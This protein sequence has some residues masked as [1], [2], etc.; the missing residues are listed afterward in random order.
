MPPAPR[1]SSTARCGKTSSVWKPFWPTAPSSEPAA[2]PENPL[3]VPISCLPEAIRSAKAELEEIDLIAPLS[4]HVGDGN[5]HF[6]LLIDREDPREVDLA[7]RFHERLVKN[8]IALEGTAS[9]EHGI[10]LGK[11]RFLE[12]EH[13]TG[14]QIM[15]AIKRA[16]DPN[17][18]LNPGKIFP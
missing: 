6:V 3:P 14:L 15:R 16:L 1:P 12:L 13:G 11:S 7:E 2:G 4:G 17:G 18:L 9:G 8:A 10:G 5:F